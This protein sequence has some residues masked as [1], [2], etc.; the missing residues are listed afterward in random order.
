MGIGL[1]MIISSSTV[2][3]MREALKIF[4]EF[5]LYEIGEVIAGEQQVRLS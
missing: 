4:P 2:A 1:I 3:K 5:P